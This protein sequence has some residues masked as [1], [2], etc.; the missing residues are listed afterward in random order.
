VLLHQFS[1]PNRRACN[2]C[3][4]ATPQGRTFNA[5]ASFLQLQLDDRAAQAA[6]VLNKA[7]SKT[8]DAR[9]EIEMCSCR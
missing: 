5:G 8:Q 2:I 9:P 4:T 1:I 3:N 6:Q 7:A